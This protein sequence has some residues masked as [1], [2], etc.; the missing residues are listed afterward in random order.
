MKRRVL[1]M[2][3]AL[4][5]ALTL[6]G[7]SGGEEQPEPT[8]APEEE[9]EQAE[10]EPAWRPKDTVNVIVAAAAGSLNDITARV[11]AQYLERD[12]GQ[13]INVENIPGAYTETNE[14]G[15]VTLQAGEGT[16][17]WKEL[18]DRK[19]D[20]L[21]LGYLEL[22]DFSNALYLWPDLIDDH[23]YTP[24]CTHTTQ[25]A[26]IIVRESEERFDSLKKMVSY[27]KRAETPLVAATN[28]ERGQLHTWTQLFCNDADLPYTASH[29][30]S[31]GAVLQCVR[32]GSADF[33]V[34]CA[35]DILERDDGLQVLAVFGQEPLPLYPD[36]PTVSELGFYP[37]WLGCA[38][39]VVAPAGIDPEAVAFYEKAFRDAMEDDRYMSASSGVTTAYKGADDTAALMSQ[40]KRIALR[41]SNSLWW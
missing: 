4:L 24:I 37:Y 39:C 12:V 22:P 7:C 35:D 29:Q 41:V 19:P 9:Q 31:V 13:S 36:A 32:D 30:S 16:A 3:L 38:C 21:T 5:T 27:G 1:A 23:S 6:T 34:V 2:L 18:A 20:G 25:T 33:A 11:L 15:E 28:G 40:Q 10:Q 26:V 8:D 14:A 17:G